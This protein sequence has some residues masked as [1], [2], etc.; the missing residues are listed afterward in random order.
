MCTEY[1]L[2]LILPIC[3]VC[4]EMT[5]CLIPFH[6]LDSFKETPDYVYY[7]QQRESK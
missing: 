1:L 5:S 3:F 7:A 2:I 6:L 4:F